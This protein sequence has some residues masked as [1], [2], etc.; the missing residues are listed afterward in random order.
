MVFPHEI[1]EMGS[2]HGEADMPQEPESH[3]LT[4]TFR[5]LGSGTSYGVPMIGCDCPVCTSSDPRNSRMRT[6]ALLEL[7]PY[8]ILIDVSTD[9]RT[10]ALRARIRHLD[11]VLITH[12][13][14][15]HIHG[16]DDL[17]A[18]SL[19]NK[20]PMPIYTDTVSVERIRTRFP[21]I[22]GDPEFRLG[23][24]IPRMELHE[25]RES[26]SLGGIQITPVPL[27]H[28]TEQIL[29][30]RIGKLAYLTDCSAIPDSSLPFLENLDTLVLDGLRQRPHPTHFS[31]S[32]A[33]DASRRIVPRQ[34]FLTHLT[35]D[36]D[37]EETESQLPDGVR[38]AFDMMSVE[39]PY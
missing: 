30:F 17:R 25:L 29:G 12:T 9:F 31:I 32:Q 28:G 26:I 34:T 6:S 8:R 13:H 11:A 5:C 38:L 36:V 24:G 14:A 18:F 10:Q 33:I 22:F 7:G 1:C 27:W 2:V 4:W 19:R 3:S 21:Y 39:I 23:W 35:H 37:H 16:I 15:D 20:S